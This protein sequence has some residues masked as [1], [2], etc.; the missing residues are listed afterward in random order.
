[1][2]ATAWATAGGVHT[3]GETVIAD[4]LRTLMG[5]GAQVFSLGQKSMVFPTGERFDP[6]AEG[7]FTILDCWFMEQF[8]K[9]IAL[10]ALA[11]NDRD[12]GR[13]A[14][15]ATGFHADLLDPLSQGRGFARAAIPR[16]AR[17]AQCGGGCEVGGVSESCARWC[18]SRSLSGQLGR[19]IGDV[20]IRIHH[21]RA[22]IGV[23]PWPKTVSRH[24]SGASK[25]ESI[26]GAGVD[27]RLE[28]FT[29]SAAASG[30]R[31]YSACVPA[32]CPKTSR[33]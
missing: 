30:R 8:A 7:D 19:I 22:V 12:Q 2:S 11:G 17:S 15:E 25:P 4:T 18:S 13:G 24:T 14:G 32:P 28:D 1:M 9:N 29:T 10:V 31:P 5:M 20:Q 6:R 3:G 26:P 23:H 33:A 21:R 16:V 27:R